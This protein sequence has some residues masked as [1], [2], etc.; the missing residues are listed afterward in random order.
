MPPNVRDWFDL[1]RLLSKY[2]R[3]A[4]LV[5]VNGL[6]EQPESWFAN[7]THLT[8]NFD[9]K[10]PD[11]LVYDGDALHRH[12]D[13]GGEV[14][15]D[16]LAG[17]LATYLDEFVQR[18]PYHLV[19]SSLGCQVILTYAA[20]HPERVARMVLIA[21]SGFHG[22]ENLPAMEGVRRSQYD[23]LVKSVFHSGRF[24][25]DDLV[26]AFEHKF[27]D[28]RWKKGV[29][30]TL[31]GTVGHSVASLLPGV[32]QPTLVIWGAEDRVLSDVPGAIRAA[33]RMPQVRQVVIPGCG[34]AP[35]IEKAGLVNQLVIAYLKDKLRSIPPALE[36]R[37]YLAQVER[38]GV[39]LARAGAR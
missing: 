27:H 35:Q 14:T 13:A 2:K 12:I 11:I 24:A 15:V 33:A 8:R 16:Y 26:R 30:R 36:P 17:R 32:S 7:R 21:P 22:D 19:G 20:R 38:R 39:A 18:P 1:P 4:P 25:S 10:V 29:L 23:T 37:R 5:L 3:R 28:R 34:H 6:A 31:R 9:L